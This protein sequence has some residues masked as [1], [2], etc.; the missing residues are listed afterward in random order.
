MK[1]INK[2]KP[3]SEETGGPIFPSGSDYA[4]PAADKEP[5]SEK[6]DSPKTYKPTKP[7][8]L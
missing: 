3:A 4:K 6:G 7:K 1:F 2:E 8:K 5:P